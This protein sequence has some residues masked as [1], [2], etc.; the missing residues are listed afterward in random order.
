M[1]IY[2]LVCFVIVLRPAC[3]ARAGGVGLITYLQICPCKSAFKN[4]N[5]ILVRM[6]LLQSRIYVVVGAITETPT[7]E[8]DS[9]LCNFSSY[10]LKVR[11]GL[12]WVGDDEAR[13][14]GC[15]TFYS[16]HS[17]FSLH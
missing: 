11:V 1:S 14:K 15:L 9:H 4:D 10:L 8:I 17:S 6:D 5:S 16:G 3:I 12:G 2:R 13:T 7:I